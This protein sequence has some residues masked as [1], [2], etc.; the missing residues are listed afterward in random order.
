MLNIRRAI[1]GA[2][3]AGLLLF[4]L[5]PAAPALASSGNVVTIYGTS[6]YQ[7][8]LTCSPSQCNVQSPTELQF[9][10]GI[11]NPQ[12]KPVTVGYKITNGT[13]TAGVDFTGPLTGT[14]TIAAGAYSTYLYIP[15]VNE[16]APDATETFTVAPTSSSVP[17]TFGPAATGTIYSQAQIPSD[18][19]MTYLTIGGYQGLSLT[20]T[21]RP[22]TQTWHF[23]VYCVPYG[24]HLHVGNT[25]T[26]DGT[27]SINCYGLVPEGT[28][29]FVTP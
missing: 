27:S 16:G 18:C 14:V 7:Y 13:A 3:A 17:A 9:Q 8:V 20:C 23:D 28:G 2:A 5:A 4:G 1:V 26:G 19:T 10:V 29:T 25:V 21:Q 11:N 22:P 12:S 6:S 24:L 15:V